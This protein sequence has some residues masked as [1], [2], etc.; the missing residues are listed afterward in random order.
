MINA[1]GMAISLERVPLAVLQSIDTSLPLIVAFCV[2]RIRI[3]KSTNDP[4]CFERLGH[5]PTLPQDCSGQAT[6]HHYVSLRMAGPLRLALISI[7]GNTWLAGASSQA[8]RKHAI[9]LDPS[10]TRSKDDR[11]APL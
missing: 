9:L 4:C 2:A 10:T 3:S 7:T 11:C 1:S 5:P 6:L 8:S